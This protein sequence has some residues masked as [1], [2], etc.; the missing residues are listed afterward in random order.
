[1]F[2]VQFDADPADPQFLY[3]NS[4]PYAISVVPDS[5]S[6][7]NF[8]AFVLFQDMT[9]A[10]VPLQ[11]TVSSASPP[12]AISVSNP[13]RGS[14]PA[15]VS[16]PLHVVALFAT[17]PTDVTGSATF[18][19]ASGSTSVVSVSTAGVLTTNGNGTDSV[20]VSYAGETTWIPITVYSAQA[21][22]TIAFGALSNVTLGVAPFTISATASSGLPVT[23]TSTTT[24]VC[25]VSGNIVTIVAAGTCSITASQ[26]GNAS[27]AAA[28]ATESFIVSQGSQAVTLTATPNPIVTTNGAT[29]G[30]TTLSWNAPGYNRLAVFVNSATG[31]QMTGTAGSTGT[32]TTGN[33]VTD[34]TR[35]FLVDLDNSS[36]I[37]SLTVH[38]TVGGAP[39][40]ANGI[41]FTATPNPIM[42]TNGATVGK[43]TLSWNAPGYNR[44]AVFVNSATGTQMTGTAGSTGTATTGNWVSDGTQFFLVDLETSSAIA[45][46]TVHVTVGGAPP[47]ANGITFTANPNPI[48]PPNGATVG[49]TTLSWNAP[50]Y[51]QLAIFVNSTSGTQMT[52]IIGSTGTAKTGNWV[53]DGTQ[54]FLVDLDTHS[55]IASLTVHVSG[56][57]PPP[58][59]VITFTANPNP[60]IPP[61]GA[62]VG[63]TTLSWNAPGYD[64][65]AVF[66]NSATGTQMTGTV[67]STGT[68]KT[69]NWVT[70][71][72][73]FFLVDLDTGSAIASLTVHVQTSMVVYSSFGANNS[74]S[75]NFLCVSGPDNLMCW[76]ALGTVAAQFTPNAT[77]TL[78]SISLALGYDGGING[79]SI[80]LLPDA[81][82]VPGGVQL[83]SWSVNNLPGGFQPALTT[84]TETGNV[85]LRA[86]QT[87]WVAVAA[88]SNDTLLLWLRNNLGLDGGMSNTGSGYQN[89]TGEGSQPAFSVTGVLQ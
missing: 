14:V 79:A 7:L 75:T 8:I 43:T 74:F 40:P 16:I 53:T 31:T 35:F 73:Q 20:N 37:D 1:M 61:N 32:A 44:L 25:T 55:A 18:S 13:P 52:G 9:Y 50:G 71:G 21:S 63:M 64:R 60:I 67:G 11:Y 72:T 84:V 87:Y 49:I 36:A 66:V 68:A 51:N 46:L 83:A 4:A 22:Q 33:W 82:G 59:N 10:S 5:L 89:L 78:Q 65:L 28:T 76:P 26:A 2:L 45:S 81:G 47:P 27:Y 15:G 62:T 56:G 85:T 24:T 80:S 58:V 70:D 39:P 54:F 17:G 42:T 29:A 41:T 19:T 86:G 88:G 48:V 30:K 23:F 12:L 38:V 57:G 69:G 6:G 34:G 77:V 3:S